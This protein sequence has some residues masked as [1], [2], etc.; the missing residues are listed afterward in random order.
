LVVTQ[1]IEDYAVI[2]DTHTIALVGRDG[3]VDWLCL[4]RFDSDAC[5][6][7]LLGDERHGYWRLAPKAP[8]SACRRRYRDGTLVLE[9]EFDCDEGTIRVVDCM[10]IRAEHPEVVRVVQGVR[11]R[12]T[13]RMELALRFGYGSVIPWVFRDAGLLRAVAGPT[14]VAVWTPVD[15]TGEDLTT[16][17]EFSVGEGQQVPFLLSFHLSHEPPPRPVDARFITE[18]TERWWKE[19]SAQSTYQGEWKEVVDRSL[20]TLKALT[21]APTGGIV[22]AATTSLP[23]DLGGVRNWDYRFCWLRDATFTLTSLMLAGYH[24][25][26]S[27]WRDWL[28]R[29]VAG[30]PRDL[31]I[32]YGAAGER[33]LD[34]Y[35]VDWLPGYE[36]SRPVRVGNAA[37]NQFQ[38]DVYGEVMD[39]LHL[40]RQAG[41]DPIETA[42]GLERVLV[43][44]L[45]TG[46]KEP[47]DGIWEVRG[48]RRHFVHSKVMA[49]VAVDRAV[50]GIEQFGVAGPVER[51][52]ALRDEIHQD[53]CA[54]G[55]NAKR[56]S[57]TQYYGSDLTD[58]SLLMIPLV[59][60][61]PPSDERV[62]GTVAAIQADL[63]EDGLVRRYQ[64]EA[65]QAVDGLTGSEGVFLACSFWLA[66]DLNLLGRN[67]EAVE[68]FERLIGLRN[69]VGLLSEEYAPSAGRQVGNFPQAFSHV[70]L[71]NCAYNLWAGAGPALIRTG[72]AAPEGMLHHHRRRRRSRIR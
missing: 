9:T 59:G 69:D 11:G 21:Y 64:T 52:R 36:G 56:Q 68:L 35:E 24:E 30:D 18:E 49:W 16:V 38:L 51:W 2:G 55:W 57:F 25:E 37:S 29:T 13:V 20:I 41:D 63:T 34:E 32:M 54:N 70:S 46:W 3:S 61:L 45:E 19:W 7:R 15:T 1:R 67:Q 28:L 17:A 10:P 27:A 58:A 26:A 33:R 5:F 65:S 40:S 8:V 12:V 50:K 47:D 66:D 42:W 60:F 23:E 14:A 62:K 4:P 6:A 53:I 43:E 48:P 39:A 71:V 72:A 44:F 31:Q 22:A